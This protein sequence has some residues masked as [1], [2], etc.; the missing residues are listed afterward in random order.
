MTEHE[1]LGVA[2]DD[3]FGTNID[4]EKTRSEL[5]I[6]QTKLGAFLDLIPAGL[7]IHQMHAVIFAN[8]E[9]GRLIGM[10]A[11]ELVGHHVFDFIEDEHAEKV[12]QS[13]AHC[14]NERETVRALE[15]GL[16]DIGGHKRVI[17]MSM[18]RLF[19][20]GLPV[21]NIVLSDI[22]VL[23][24]KERELFIL[25]TTDSLTGAYNRRY[26]MDT[27]DREFRRFQML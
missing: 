3:L 24:Q 2:D 1:A 11:E 14:F 15:V 8:A 12:R 27:A 23:K 20:E 7:V 5:R 25:S 22:T 21:I 13:F 4:A 18:S 19:W 17:Q 9:A 26:F 6:A 16:I 10:P